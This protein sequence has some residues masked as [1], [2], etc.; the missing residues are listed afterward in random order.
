MTCRIGINL[1]S[2]WRNL[3]DD[4]NTMRFTTGI[5]FRRFFG[6]MQFARK[7]PEAILDARRCRDSAHAAIRVRPCWPQTCLHDPVVASIRVCA[8]PERGFHRKSGT[9]SP[10]RLKQVVFLTIQ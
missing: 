9:L 3:E 4:L 5:D 10:R 6:F 1:T 7:V 8:E 2:G